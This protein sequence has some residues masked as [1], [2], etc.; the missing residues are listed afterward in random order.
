MAKTFEKRPDIS[1]KLWD[2]HERVDKEPYLVSFTPLHDILEHYLHDF[3]NQCHGEHTENVI[4]LL[5]EYADKL[6]TELFHFQKNR[7]G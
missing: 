3:S 1:F 6:E 4:N 7:T 2:G 5:R